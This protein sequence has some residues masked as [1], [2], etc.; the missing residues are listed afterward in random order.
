MSDNGSQFDSKEMEQVAKFYCF[1]HIPSSL[2]YHQSNGLAEN[3]VKNVK[4][5]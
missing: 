4:R 1:Q 3:M 2:H 5:Y